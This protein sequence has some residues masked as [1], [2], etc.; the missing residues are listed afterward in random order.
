MHAS[1]AQGFSIS[2]ITALPCPQ[3]LVTIHC[4]AP[5]HPFFQLAPGTFCGA[6]DHRTFE[7]ILLGKLLPPF[8]IG[9]WNKGHV[10]K[11][12]RTSEI[13]FVKTETVYLARAQNLR[14]PVNLNELG[15]TQQNR[16]RQRVHISTHPELNDGEP[17]LIKLA[18]W[19]WEIASIEVETIAYQ[20]IHDS[21][22]GRKFFGHLTEGKNG[23]GVSFVVEWV[24]GARAAGSGDI[25]SCKKA[26]GRLHELGIKF[27]D[28][29]EDNF[30]VRDGHDVV[31]VDFET[32]KHNWSPQ[33]LED[34]MNT[35]KSSLE[36]TNSFG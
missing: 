22:I 25:E 35:L 13:T 8:P 34:E 32:A 28:I 27:G 9:D 1:L 11:D 16:V 12:P 19:T 31:L 7:P 24:Q 26:L 2:Q 17:V 30:L 15:F 18:V 21:G 14:Q 10:A 36:G 3:T 23:R 29:N 4:L 20:W 5:V 6:E 33:E